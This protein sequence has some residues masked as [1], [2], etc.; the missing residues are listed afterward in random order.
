M[1]KYMVYLC[2]THIQGPAKHKV[3]KGKSKEVPIQ[4]DMSD[5]EE[6]SEV[7]YTFSLPRYFQLT[8]FGT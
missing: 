5:M 3:D 4:V 8:L 6:D 2:T 1:H 7:C